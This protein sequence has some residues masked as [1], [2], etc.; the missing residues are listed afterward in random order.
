MVRGIDSAQ[1]YFRGHFAPELQSLIN[2]LEDELRSFVQNFM[3]IH[4]KKSNEEILN[5]IFRLIDSKKENDKFISPLYQHFIQFKDVKEQKKNL[6]HWNGDKAGI[7]KGREKLHYVIDFLTILGCVID[8]LKYESNILLPI[9]QERYNY[10]SNWGGNKMKSVREW[11]EHQ[12]CSHPTFFQIRMHNNCNNVWHN[13]CNKIITNRNDEQIKDDLEKPPH[14]CTKYCKNKKGGIAGDMCNKV[15]A[16]S[17]HLPDEVHHEAE[18]NHPINPSVVHNLAL[19]SNESSDFHDPTINH[20][21]LQ[22]VS[23]VPV[24]VVSPAVHDQPP[25]PPYPGTGTYTQTNIPVVQGV[26]VPPS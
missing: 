22:E 8:T 1:S 9:M 19:A 25:P 11:L 15:H 12:I 2:Q 18:G 10:L 7:K 14:Y 4:D 17:T 23:A 5:E 26:Y 20:K 3:N 13:E 16:M 21:D 24:P 6:W